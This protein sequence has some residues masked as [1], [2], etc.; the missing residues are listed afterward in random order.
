MEWKEKGYPH[1]KRTTEKKKIGGYTVPMCVVMSQTSKI[2][3]NR[4]DIKAAITF[5]CT[6]YWIYYVLLSL[7]IQFSAKTGKPVFC[8]LNENLPCEWQESH[9]WNKIKSFL[10]E[11]IYGSYSFSW[12]QIFLPFCSII[13]P[14]FLNT[15]S[16]K[17]SVWLALQKWLTPHFKALSICM[18]LS[19]NSNIG[20]PF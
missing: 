7:L 11:A 4:T 8:F 12:S 14:S 19:E 15:V 6:D 10:K 13:C 18:V 9:T 2:I 3:W 1:V 5:Q 16:R 20:V 17:T